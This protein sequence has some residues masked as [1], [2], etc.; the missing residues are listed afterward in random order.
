MELMNTQ[1]GILANHPRV[2]ALQ[3]AILKS[4]NSVTADAC[5]VVHHFSPGAYAREMSI[6]AGL[7][8]VGKIHRHA[9]LNIIS[10]GVLEVFTE[11]G[12]N[13]RLEAPC[14]FVSEPGI[15]RVIYACEDSV[16]TSVHVTNKTD[17]AEIEAEVI[18]PEEI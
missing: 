11:A 8:I 18:I 10:K 16:W 6:P 13:V 15:K 17:L 5:P 4:E 2:L 9:H 14:T 1:K 12:G 3:N 7:V